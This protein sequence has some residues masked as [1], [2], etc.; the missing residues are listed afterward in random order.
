MS[1]VRVSRKR[2]FLLSAIVVIGL[3]LLVWQWPNREHDQ[4]VLRLYGNIDLRQVSLAFNNSERIIEVLAQEGDRVQQGQVLARLDTSRLA[5]R[6]AEAAAQAEAQKQVVERMH[7]GSRPEEIAQAR[8]NLD[9]ARADADYAHLQYQRLK[10]LSGD[11]SGRAVS[12]Q[13]LDSSRSVMSSTEARVMLNKKALD[14]ALIG[15]RKEDIAQAE[16]QLR[17]YEAQL[18]YLR[19]QIKDAELPAPSNA[20]VRS[21]LLEPGEMSSPQRPVYSL[22]LVDPK[23]VRAYVGEADL[24][25]LHPGAAAQVSVDS[26]PGRTFD[27]WIGFISPV[28]EFTPKPVQTEELRPS[29]SYEVRVFVKDPIDNLRLGMPAT[30]HVPLSLPQSKSDS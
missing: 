24:G 16:A 3:G 18:T 7:N 28:A 22:A 8:A 1:S 26:F 23:W 30:V 12:K 19:Q 2:W 27:G 20:I 4:S 25:L 11:S 29:L 13:D 21:R 15:P 17:S 5:P 10:L 14:L 9:A 6:V